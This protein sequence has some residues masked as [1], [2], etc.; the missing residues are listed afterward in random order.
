MSAG[1]LVQMEMR[2]D[3]LRTSLASIRLDGLL[4]LDRVISGW[5]A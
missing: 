5:D 3:Y 4:V 1:Y 2:D